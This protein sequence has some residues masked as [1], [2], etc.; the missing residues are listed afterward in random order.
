MN[1]NCANEKIGQSISR[2][3]LDDSELTELHGKTGFKFY[4]FN[5]FYPIEKDGIY[6]AGRVYIFKIRS[7]GEEFIK[8][9]KALL[10]KTECAYRVL[11]VQSKTVKKSF[12]TNLYTLTPVIVTV[13]GRGWAKEEDFMLLQERLQGNL[14]KKYNDFFGKEEFKKDGQGTFIQRI[15]LLNRKP[16]TVKYKDMKFIGNKFKIWVNEDESSQ[17]LAFTALACGLGEKNTILGAG[18]CTGGDR[19]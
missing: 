15:E 1:F 19:E 6:K 17:K 9:M 7:F 2:I 13:N 16:M 8:K 10:P 4:N 5:S 11:S 12:L 3:M 18:F 14:E